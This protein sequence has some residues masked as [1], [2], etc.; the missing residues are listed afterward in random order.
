MN[1]M[2]DGVLKDM[3]EIQKKEDDMI[4]RYMKEFDSKTQAAEQAKAKKRADIQ[5]N[6]NATLAKQQEHKEKVAK[7]MKDHFNEQ[8]GMWAKE[9]DLWKEEDARIKEKIK[10]INN[11]NVA[12]LQQQVEFKKGKETTKMDPL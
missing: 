12:Y 3:A 4:N 8:A 6:I 2:A 9:R 5:A 10:K 7:E 1:R 11:D